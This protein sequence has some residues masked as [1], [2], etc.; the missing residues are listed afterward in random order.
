[1][2]ALPETLTNEE[3]IQSLA[4]ISADLALTAERMASFSVFSD[5]PRVSLQGLSERIPGQRTPKLDKSPRMSVIAFTSGS[6]S[7]AKLKAFRVDLESVPAFTDAFTALFG[8]TRNDLW[9]VCHSFTHIVHLEY[10]LGG[11][12][13]GYDVAL[14]D[15]VNVLMNGAQLRPSVLVT[16]PSVYEQLANQIRRRFPKSGAR[17]EELERLLQQSLVD[18]K[19]DLVRRPIIPEAVSVVGD[20]L[21]IMLIGAAPSSVALQGFLMKIGPP[22]F[23]G[24]GMSE[25]Y[26]IACN[27]P[28]HARAGTV[29]GLG[30]VSR[31]GSTR[32]ESC[33]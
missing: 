10:V 4:G 29:A 16:V 5:I 33:R 6:T 15:V 26:M 2:A 20:R 27:T 19:G 21:K 3:A 25:T 11:L 9:V 31:C 13:W 18:A 1:M 28:G 7:G 24:Y 30:P 17:A 22:L 23:E 32:R 8:I 12:G 14:T